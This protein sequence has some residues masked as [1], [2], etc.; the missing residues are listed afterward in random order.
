MTTPVEAWFEKAYIKGATHKLQS[1]GFLLKGT[2]RE[3]DRVNARDLVWRIAG[4]GEA[5]EMSNTIE[6]A[7]PMNAG[8][9]TV[10]G[11]IK[12]Y[13]AAD[14]IR[15]PDINKMSEN[16]QQIVQQ[17]ASMALGRKFDRIIFDEFDTL[18][19]GDNIGDGTTDITLLDV[20]QAEAEI[21]GQGGND[22]ELFCPLPS[23][24]FK[25]LQLYEQ[26]SSADY[27][28]PDY[29][30]ARM[31]VRKKWG[32]CTYFM[33]P[34]QMFTFDTG[35]G[36]EAWKTATW[37]QTYMWMKSCTGFGTNYEMQSRITWEN[38]YTA[39]FA[40][41]WMPGCAKIIL[42]EGLRRIKMKFNAPLVDPH[43]P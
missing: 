30:L 11:T 41:N 22:M 10:E 43:A 20:M 7:Q 14:W 19:A 39:Y 35:V 42:P 2:T 40:N 28:G 9:E 38:Q 32:F 21:M 33:A 3:P 16:E 18:G 4:T 12:D 29:P 15:H 25:Q 5:R 37:F 17:T 27:N 1:Q 26:F 8:R 6:R 24:A 23:L 31:T 36:L 34:N 13:Q